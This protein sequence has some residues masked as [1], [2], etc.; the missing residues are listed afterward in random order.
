MASLVKKYPGG[1][2]FD[3]VEAREIADTINKL[4]SPTKEP[5]DG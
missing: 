5:D 4:V 1:S 2:I 3:Y